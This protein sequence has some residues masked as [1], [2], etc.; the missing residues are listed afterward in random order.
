MLVLAGCGGAVGSGVAVGKVGQQ[1]SS[2]A[3]AGPQ[4]SEVCALKDALA[5]KQGA[6]KDKP[7]EEK[8]DKE[9]KADRVWNGSI[10]ALS[11][12]GDTLMAVSFGA[13]S[14]VVGQIESASAGAPPDAADAADGPEK[15]ARDGAAALLDMLAKKEK[16]D[17]LGELVTRAGPHVKAICD[18]LPGYLDAQATGITDALKEAEKKRASPADRR[19]A[20]VEGSKPICVGDSPVDRVV[21]ASTYGRLT[22][23]KE[24]HTRARDGVAGFCAAHVKLE[25]AAKNG[26]LKDDETVTAIAEAVKSARGASAA[27]A[28][29]SE[30]PAGETKPAEAKPAEAKPAEAKPA[31]TEPK[32]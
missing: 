29:P 22:K 28:P 8:C 23:L 30:T 26:T 20:A 10:H 6:E 2:H 5:P 24:A 1:L 25:E 32:K 17:D 16:K 3:H 15:A 13:G 12:Y 9:L 31:A 18:G 19:C 27:S 14:E 4:G 21:Y 11:A 7:I